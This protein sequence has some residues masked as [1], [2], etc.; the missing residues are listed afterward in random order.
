MAPWI[1]DARKTGA[2]HSV[3]LIRRI[4]LYAGIELEQM[5]EPA[6]MVTMPMRNR[7]EVDISQVDA[8]RFSI[9]GERSRV[10]AGVEQDAL[11]AKLKQRSKAPILSQLRPLAERVVK[12]GYTI[13]CHVEA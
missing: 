11:S 12:D 9:L 2:K 10:I 6:G 5:V 1:E 3:R 13:A 7:Y 8:E 4:Y